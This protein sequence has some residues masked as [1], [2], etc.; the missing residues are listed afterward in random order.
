MPRELTAWLAVW[1]ILFAIALWMLA[2]GIE[3]DY[4]TPVEV[5]PPKALAPVGNSL[6]EPPS[7]IPGQAATGANSLL[8]LGIPEIR[9]RYGW[10]NWDDVK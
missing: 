10:K 9:P 4:A 5:T 1:I 2:E 6:T 8:R 7:V 3:R